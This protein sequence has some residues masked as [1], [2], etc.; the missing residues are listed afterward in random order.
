MISTGPSMNVVAALAKSERLS[1]PPVN[2]LFV[3]RKK[4]RVHEYGEQLGC[5]SAAEVPEARRLR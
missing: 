1:L 5:A 2:R 4:T 3:A